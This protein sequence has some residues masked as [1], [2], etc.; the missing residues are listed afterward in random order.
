MRPADDTVSKYSFSSRHAISDYNGHGTNVA[1]QVSSKAFA[2]AGVTSRTTL[3]GVKVLGS[4]GV[5]SLGNVL[6]GVIWA[7]DHDADVANMSLGGGFPRT[8]NQDI[9]NI[10]RR[11]FDY[12]KRKRMLVVVSAGN[13]GQD[14]DN[15]GDTYST[16]CDAPH[17]ICVSAVGPTTPTGNPDEPAFYTNF[18]LRSIDVAAPGGN[19]DLVGEDPLEWPWGPDFGSFVWS[20]C[21]KTLIGSWTTTN[22]PRTLP[23]AAGN[24]LYGAIGTSQAAPHVAGLAALL[25]S[26]SHESNSSEI[27]R[28]ILESADDL[29]PRGRDAYYGEGRINVASGLRYQR[30]HDNDHR[31]NDDH[32]DDDGRDG[33]KSDRH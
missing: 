23:C 10:I 5:G 6:S 27:K 29:G 19:L 21:S 18:G 14:L 32:R 24:R 28:A 3:I 15:N 26:V 1:T 30:R 31:G 17:V 16:Y 33:K 9:V 20:L 7:A 2:F 8:G 11:V 4:N 25:S 22:A 12:A 13:A